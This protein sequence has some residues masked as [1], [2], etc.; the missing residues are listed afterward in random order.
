MIE[1]LRAV[2]LLASMVEADDTGTTDDVYD[3]YARDGEI[4]C[5]REISPCH[6]EVEPAECT[7][8][9]VWTRTEIEELVR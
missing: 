6:Y 1:L 2:M 9:V 4:T 7:V 8:R 5:E 3:C